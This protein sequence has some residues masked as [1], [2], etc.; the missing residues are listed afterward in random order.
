MKHFANNADYYDALK[1]IT[2]Y[3]KPERLRSRS[4]RDY[5]LSGDEA[6]EMAYENVLNEAR[7]A[8]K[9]KRR[10]VVKTEGEKRVSN[11]NNVLDIICA[12]AFENS[13]GTEPVEPIDQ[14][15][16]AEKS[17]AARDAALAELAAIK[18]RLEWGMRHRA[19]GE[20]TACGEAEAKGWCV[21]FPDSYQL[22]IRYAAGPWET[23]DE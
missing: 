21:R 8:I 22:L 15:A 14:R 17:E 20:T 9:G 11:I 5:G 1:R 6:L 13:V 2:M 10:L 3:D 7:I 4:E 16:R 19:T 12:K 18:G 23:P